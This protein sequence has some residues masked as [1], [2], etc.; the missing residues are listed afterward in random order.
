MGGR[1]QSP[2]GYQRE[3]VVNERSGAGY[4]AYGNGVDL[5]KR[6]FEE[7]SVEDDNK[8]TTSSIVKSV[9]KKT[10]GNL[11]GR[12]KDKDKKESRRKNRN[13]KEEKKERRAT[14]IFDMI[15]K[16]ASKSAIK[17][18]NSIFLKDNESEKENKEDEETDEK[19]KVKD[20]ETENQNED[21]DDKN[22]ESKV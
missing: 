2:L 15:I 18:V 22:T 7:T 1:E 4:R 17:Y 9:W 16:V 19:E 11:F 5:G 12:K 14:P 20:E 21:K 6:R 8:K 10:L 3:Y 13:G